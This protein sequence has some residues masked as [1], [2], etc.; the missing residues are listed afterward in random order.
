MK[1]IIVLGSTGSIGRQ[2]LEVIRSFPGEFKLLGLGA[3]KNWRL[4][5]DQ[6]KEFRPAAAALAEEQE[7]LNL[8]NSLDPTCC[9]DLAWGRQGM[10][11]LAKLPG[12]ELVVVAIT[13]AAGIYP[14]LAAL[15]AGKDVA[16]ANKETLVAAGQLVMDLASRKNAAILPVD[17]EHSAIWQC[18]NGASPG[19]IE[20]IILTASGGPFR[21]LGKKQ[22][23]SVTVDMALRH[24][25]WVMGSK[26]T[27]DSA[28]LMNK[29]LEVIEAKWLFGVNYSQIEVVI[30]P[31]SVIHS[32]VEFKD[33]SVLA[34][35]GV[36]DMRLPIQHA[37]TY[38]DRLAGSVP[39]LRLTDLKGLTFEEPDQTR[40]PA[41]GLAFEAGRTG[42]TMPAV[43]SAA[44]EIAVDLFLREELPFTGIP[45]LVGKVMEQHRIIINPGLGDIM[46]ADR[47]ARKTARQAVFNL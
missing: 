11:D 47:W 29:G 16:L 12:A 2:T 41:L 38:P 13:G 10:E 8:Q 27:V 1:K 20:K 30:H 36:P 7:L 24:P 15:N 17:S 25:N 6:I 9:P 23:E 14:T 45:A 44:N 32:A 35:M 40:F 46:E 22:L 33:G 37:L 26:I 5:S 42:G 39:R 4:L 18:L 19:V 43:L 34:Q 3:G 21:Q 28:T 31:Q